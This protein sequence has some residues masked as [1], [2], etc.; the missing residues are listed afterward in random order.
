MT[1]PRYLKM[2]NADPGKQQAKLLGRKVV[3]DNGCW[4]WPG[5]KTPLGY[6]QMRVG[7]PAG[8][9]EYVHRISHRLF[10]GPIP[11]GYDVD[12]LC[13]NTSCYNPEHLEAVPH[14]TNVLRGEA[15]GSKV[16]R[17]NICGKG[18][19]D[20]AEVGYVR[21]DGSRQCRECQR[22]WERQNAPRSRERRRA[23]QEQGG[24]KR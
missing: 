13:R 12:H 15:P 6:G 5:Q 18:L 17:T 3:D 11:D 23:R 14:R 2:S 16:A 8:R 7:P 4:N 1:D 10:V 22:E 21:T 20:M 24:R 19:H 9:R